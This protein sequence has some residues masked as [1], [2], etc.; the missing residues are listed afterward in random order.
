MP[1]SL[2]EKT[3]VWIFVVAAIFFLIG[4]VLLFISTTDRGIFWFVLFSIV[5]IA[6]F[7][8]SGASYSYSNIA[9]QTVTTSVVTEGVK[10]QQTIQQPRGYYQVPAGYAVR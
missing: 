2:Y 6:F 4:L 9:T 5:A 3:Y 7:F 1:E 10:P 8:A